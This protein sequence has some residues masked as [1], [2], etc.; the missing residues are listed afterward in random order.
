MYLVDF[1]FSES[2]QIQEVWTSRKLKLLVWFSSCTEIFILFYFIF[3]LTSHVLNS[4]WFY[5]VM[6]F[7]FPVQ[8][9]LLNLTVFIF[10]SGCTS[11]SCFYFPVCKGLSLTSVFLLFYFFIPVACFA[12]S[13]LLCFFMVLLLDFFYWS[14]FCLVVKIIQGST[15]LDSNSSFPSM[16]KTLQCSLGAHSLLALL[17]LTPLLFLCLV[18]NMIQCFCFLFWIQLLGNFGHKQTLIPFFSFVLFYFFFL[19]FFSP[20]T[21]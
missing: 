3:Y 4:L 15:M 9:L 10:F 17:T 20:A 5:F 11:V 8:I 6:H 12:F 19:L 14:C 2:L 16:Y 13:F 21:F 18:I 7:C 1:L